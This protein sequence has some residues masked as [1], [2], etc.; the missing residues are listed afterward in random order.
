M[1]A[2]LE[3][4]DD[5]TRVAT[6]TNLVDH[7]PAVDDALR[8]LRK[9]LDDPLPK[10]NELAELALYRLLKSLSV[11][12]IVNVT[13]P[14]FVEDPSVSR[15]SIHDSSS[16]AFSPPSRSRGPSPT[17][18][19]FVDPRNGSGPEVRFCSVSCAGPGQR[20]GSYSHSF[21][22][23][24]GRRNPRHDPHQHGHH[25]RDRNREEAKY[26]VELEHTKCWFWRRLPPRPSATRALIVVV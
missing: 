13:R 5:Q 19:S 10:V 3:D 8:L 25:Q 26:R 15:R 11:R 22:G 2:D 17:C 16:L 1:L 7:P 24:R 12:R 6:A 4:G 21:V 14:G 18:P 23:L 9:A 20:I